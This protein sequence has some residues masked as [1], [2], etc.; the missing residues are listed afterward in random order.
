MSNK[1]TR[2]FRSTEFD[3]HCCGK[4]FIDLGIVHRLQVLRD[5]L[6]V[7]IIVTS[8]YRC[9]RHN[10]EIGGAPNSMHLKGWAVDWTCS[11][12][13]EAARLCE[14]WSGGFHYYPEEKFIHTD[15][16]P[17]RRW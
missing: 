11:K 4:N 9:G 10:R 1:I 5:I 13:E 14:N 6:Q 17:R 15:I 2:G 12:I 8:G 16:G 7:P 3:C